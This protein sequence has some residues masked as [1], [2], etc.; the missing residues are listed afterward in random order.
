MNNHINFEREKTFSDLKRGKFRYDFYI[1]KYNILIEYDGEQH[2]RHIHHFQ[3]LRR[4]FLKQ[5]EHDRQKNSYALANNI[6][7]F[8]IPYWEIDNIKCFADLIQ[9]K[10]CVTTKWWN[11]IIWR[12]F[13]SY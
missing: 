8:R 7:L 4:D 1:P 9:W 11:D 2:F 6:K 5:Q 3:K 10:Y 13:T 12:K